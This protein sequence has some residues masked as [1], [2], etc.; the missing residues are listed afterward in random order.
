MNNFLHR[1]QNEILVFDGAMG[2]L[3][4]ASGLPRGAC[5]D[6]WNLSHPE[7]VRDCH[8]AYF[9]AGADAVQTNTFGA[10]R[11]RLKDYGLQDQVEEINVRGARMAREAAFGAGGD[12]KLV[13]GSIGPS[14]K[15]LQPFGEL[16][17]EAAYDIFK[18]QAQA[19]IKGGVDLLIIETMVDLQEMRA[20]LLA[21]R[22][23]SPVPIIAQMSFTQDSRTVTGTD[24]VT[25]L[26][27]LSAMGADVVGA[28]C[29]IGPAE[30]L[31]VFER[32]AS[33]TDHPL[34]AQP[35]AGMPQLVGDETVF[36][37]TPE[38]IAEYGE[39]F[40]LTGAN[41]V[42]SCC[43]TS[44]EHTKALAQRVKH[45]KP[46]QRKH[47]PGTRLTSRVKTV[48]AGT[49]YPFVAIGERINPSGRKLLT[50][51]I[52]EGKSGLLRRD[53]QAQVQAGAMVL[54]INV[55]IAGGDLSEPRY[56]RNAIEAVQNVVDSPLAI[57]TTGPEALTAGLKTCV[58]K[59]LVNSISGEEA[60][61]DLLM[62]LVKRFGAAFIGLALDEQGIPATARDRLKVAE[63]ILT[64]ARE[65]GIRSEDIVI[66]PL[67]L[68][69][70]TNQDDSGVTLETIALVKRHL[71]LTTS[72]GLSNVSFGLPGRKHVNQAY[73]VQALSYGLDMA[74]VNPLDET[75]MALVRAGD[76]LAGRDRNARIYIETFKAE[77]PGEASAAKP[78]TTGPQSPET[79]LF[80][81]I[82]EGDRNAVPDVLVEILKKGAPPLQ[83]INETMIPAIRQV[84]EAF[85]QGRLFLPQ[86]MLSAEAMKVAFGIL[87][88]LIQSV[89]PNAKGAGGEGTILMATVQGDVHDIG[90]NLVIAVLESHGY[91]VADLGK[92]VTAEK[93]IAQARETD[94]DIVGLSALMT[95]TM[96]EMRQVAKTMQEMGLRARLMIGGAP[97][98][99]KF[100]REIGAQ[101]YGR[102]AMDAVRVVRSLLG[103]DAMKIEDFK[104]K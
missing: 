43:G 35:N 84:G 59:P 83:V 100:A 21:A 45:L 1:L 41:I 93:I 39:K 61:M 97:V 76:V 3:L 70:S 71:G 11:T 63:R 89:A 62:P 103:K 47:A 72:F 9:A 23:V 25:A 78:Q 16:S 49:G 99:E 40:V 38:L 92:N 2:T 65:H 14:G 96:G 87:R 31:P 30:M 54:D 64:K 66:D 55:G 77:G 80:K 33:T 17:F 18:E 50:R 88:P 37:G 94:A 67:V 20:A 51:E 90:K 4:Q 73:L 82:L 28:N 22:D 104:S 102:D 32:L 95:T 101:A 26:S 74:I 15:F 8:R 48:F 10:T 42:G 98:T 56:M 29:M 5:P 6:E 52:E 68:T 7:K 69:V 85:D 79:V 75:L 19:L 34:S 36:P 81:A 12:G 13:A 60:R 46:I 53:A 27:V 24:P 57:D 58:G 86:L 91:R 44:P